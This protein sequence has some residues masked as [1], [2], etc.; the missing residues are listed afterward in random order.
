VDDYSESK[1]QL[2]KIGMKSQFENCMVIILPELLDYMNPMDPYSIYKFPK[3]YIQSVQQNAKTFKVVQI[4]EESKDR[5]LLILQRKGP[6][7]TEY[8]DVQLP[9][10]HKSYD[11]TFPGK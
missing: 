5:R 11:Y 9:Y 6:G 1:N 2:V 8:P 7:N 10:G 3:T 4:F